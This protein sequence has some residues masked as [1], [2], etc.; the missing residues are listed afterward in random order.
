MLVVLRTTHKT[1]LQQFI[2]TIFAGIVILLSAMPVTA[3]QNAMWRY[4]VRPGDN[5]ITIGKTHL[6]NP[7]DWK[8]VQRL[9]HIKNPYRMPAGKVLRVPLGLVKQGP[10]SA[11]VIFV[12]G[13]VQWQ[14]SATNFEPLKIGQNLGAG[15]NIETKEN[16]KVVIQFADETT[17]ELS[18]NSIMSLDTMSLYSGG[19]MVDTKLR[20]QNGQLET[21]ANPRHVKG[22]K[23]RVITPSAIAA[24]RGT[25][26]RV[27]ANQKATTQETLDGQV[28]LS[29]LDNEV[30]VNKGFGSKAELGKAPTPPVELLPA[31]DT[32]N[33]KNQYEA[34]PITFDMPKMQGATAWAGKIAVDAQSSQIVAENEVQG[35]QLVFV[36]V[37]DGQYYLSLRAKD[38]NGIAGYDASHQFTLNAR[39]IQPEVVSPVLNSTVREDQPLLHWHS[40][41]DA[42]FYAVEV[43][44]D[45]DFKNLHEVKKVTGTSSKLDKKLMQGTYFWRVS[46]IAKN[47][48][49]QEDK[50]P[51]IKVSQ[52]TY[53]PTPVMPDISQLKIKIL[54]NRV[55][56]ETV[57][58]L[59]GLVYQAK[60]DNEFNDQKAV[61]QGSGLGSEFNFLLKE[62]GKQTLYIWHLDSDGVVSPSAI[63][64]FNAP[65]Q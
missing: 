13:Q 54:N 29:A 5:L 35:N 25:K 55:F 51:A 34:L 16:S 24:V 28:A 57:A 26:F 45:A 63:Y 40:I 9:N 30:V 48:Q 2:Q 4:T 17:A 62:Y 36:D 59:S 61:W 38:K 37:P 60:L 50:G 44:T 20:L 11:E 21:H 19:V 33:L 15:A 64:E 56:V 49:G 14:Q 3:E 31:A 53:K 27:T 22:N 6:I 43:A 12:S 42:Q 32:T 58:P 41:A 1:N 10:A 46:S 23:I 8:E 18:S 7:D 39:P 52:F 65:P 47:E